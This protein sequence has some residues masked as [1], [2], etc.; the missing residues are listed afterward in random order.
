MQPIIVEAT[1]DSE[2][3][4]G[5]KDVVTCATA[6]DGAF[7]PDDKHSALQILAPLMGLYHVR[8]RHSAVLMRQAF[9]QFCGVP[10]RFVH[11]YL[12]TDEEGRPIP[13]ELGAFKWK[14]TKH[15]ACIHRRASRERDRAAAPQNGI[16]ARRWAWRGLAV[17]SAVRP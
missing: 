10:P 17:I 15:L 9:D 3:D 14:R 1:G 12:P 2:A 4:F 16:G 7:I 13:P 8:G 11:F 6:S 5:P